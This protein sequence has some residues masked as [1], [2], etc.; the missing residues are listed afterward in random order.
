[1]D[2]EDGYGGFYSTKGPSF[3]NSSCGYKN[4]VNPYPS[5]DSVEEFTHDV[6]SFIEKGDLSEAI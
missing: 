2:A 3:R 1:M 4:L 5:Y 6:N